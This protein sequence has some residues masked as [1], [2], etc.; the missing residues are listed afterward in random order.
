MIEYDYQMNKNDGS[1][2]IHYT[3][4][5][6]TTITNVAKLKGHNSSGKTTLMDMIALS[7]YGRDS[8]DVIQKLQD[9]LEYLEKSN[10]SE[11]EFK[12][13]ANN[14]QKY[15]KISTSKKGYFDGNPSWET[16]IE[17]SDDGVNY[18]SL[19]KESFKRK[20][21]L[22]YD[23]PDRPMERIQELVSEAE[24]EL[25]E[26]IYKLQD[27]RGP[28][29]RIINEVESSRNEELISL[30][31]EEI[32]TLSQNIKNKNEALEKS[33]KLLDKLNA[34][35]V[36]QKLKNESDNYSKIQDNLNNLQSFDK[37]KNSEQKKNLKN[38]EKEEKIVKSLLNKMLYEYNIAIKNISYISKVDNKILS[39]FCKQWDGYD[40]EKIFNI[41]CS[42][43]YNYTEK[44]NEMIN[45]IKTNY[46]KNGNDKLI[47]KKEM[48]KNLIGVLEPYVSDKLSVLDT[49]VSELYEKLKNEL[50]ELSEK[51]SEYENAMAILNH[52]EI[53]K[54]YGKDADK[55]FNN[56]GEKPTISGNE[57]VLKDMLEAK[58]KEAEQS[59]SMTKTIAESLG[60]SYEDCDDIIDRCIL[61]NDLSDYVSMDLQELS[62]EI[63]ELKSHN[64]REETNLLGL[65]S[66]LKDQEK[67]LKDA[68]QKQ[69]H[70]LH[71]YK[72]ELKQLKDV[73]EK[74]IPTLKKKDDILSELSRGKQ[75]NESEDN[76]EFLHS[77]WIYLGKK[78]K[79]I[80]HVGQI[81]DVDLI[82]MNKREV[83]SGD[84][85]INFRDMGTGE[86][87]MAYLTGLLNSDDDRTIIALFDEV[88][89][90]DPKVISK[91]QNRMKSMLDDGKLLIGLMAA[92]GDYT[93]VEEY[94]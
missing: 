19:L 92:P 14:G 52:I 22:I 16:N 55:K 39:S 88:D 86:S 69:A 8:P 53:S 38:Y 24:R 94:E 1:K 20:Y 40:S 74:M 11:F 13:K 43:I 15:L 71:D 70:P 68:Q 62:T 54:K 18:T 77:I 80:Q 60:I 65:N 58:L 85:H 64:D 67:S 79:T 42:V 32:T 72:K 93:E 50:S 84:V 83:I 61:D 23:M 90:M 46:H 7:L 44:C 27:I 56:L 91:I 41:N 28:L 21:R 59:L 76:S 5:F 37:K 49:N 87:Q 2:I 17:E 30:L 34:Y 81:Y 51:I 63:S 45:Q 29:T 36:S 66:T 10:T 4:N 78:L 31:Q 75:V 35:Y 3:P 33:S 89:H 9:K 26:N 25:N 48:L 73:I 57:A 12:L 6:K 47:E 82:D